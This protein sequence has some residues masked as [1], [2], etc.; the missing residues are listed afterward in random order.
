MPVRT[1][2]FLLPLVVFASAVVAAP[3]TGAPPPWWIDPGDVPL[4]EWAK[5]VEIIR[6]DE[7]LQASPGGSRRGLIAAGVRLPLLGATRAPGCLSRWLL[8]GPLAYVCQDK[9]KLS[10]EPPGVAATIHP[11]PKDALPFKYWFVGSNGAEAYGSVREAEDETPLEQLDRGWSIAG[12]SETVHR[13][14]TYVV[15]RRG[16]LVPRS[17]LGAIV[18]S[19]FRGEELDA[20][21][22]APIGVG[23]ILPEKANVV[24]DPSKPGAKAAGT[25]TRLSTIAIAERKTIGKV[26]WLR[27]GDAEWIRASDARVP[28]L[29][30][31]PAE[32]APA[33]RWI[34]VDT[35]TQTLVAYE[36]DRP[37]FATVVSTGRAATPTP[38]GVF[39]IWVKL[40]TA[41]MSNAD[42]RDLPEDGSSYSIEDVP[43]VQYFS[44]GIALHGAFW[45]R[46]FGHPHSHGCVNLAPLDAMRLFGWTTPR[47]PRG[48][49]A[50][51]PT[52][53]EASTVVR[54]R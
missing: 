25:R 18:A 51:F 30:A 33:A 11:E 5:S 26:E 12:V 2:F 47:L 49:D 17:Q 16:R 50:A 28:V 3:A 21:P 27:I 32:V 23:W 37:V 1:T 4:P 22:G 36:G 24:A 7:P 31:R 44:N 8:V 15:T 38:R 40:R 10:E 45:H 48:W 19:A 41:K 43:W 46:R 29:A 6:D 20:E 34:D 9:V 39:K 35:A 54:V 52:A 14:T 13:G 53:A 42:D